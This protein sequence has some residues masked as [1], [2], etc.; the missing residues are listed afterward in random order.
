MNRIMKAI[1]I[2]SVNLK[3]RGLQE[4]VHIYVFNTDARKYYKKR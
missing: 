3:N 2:S 4:L 1:S